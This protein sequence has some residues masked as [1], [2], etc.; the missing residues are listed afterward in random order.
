LFTE[1]HDCPPKEQLK[2]LENML[3]GDVGAV[4]TLF[5]IAPLGY[6]TG[7]STRGYL[8][9]TG[10]EHLEMN[11]SNHLV[12]KFTTSGDPAVDTQQESWDPATPWYEAKE[13]ADLLL[14][15]EA[16]MFPFEVRRAISIFKDFH[17]SKNPAGESMYPAP[18]Y[19]RRSFAAMLQFLKTRVRVN[20]ADVISF[21]MTPE[22]MNG[23]PNQLFTGSSEGFKTINSNGNFSLL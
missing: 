19:T 13:F 3:L 5:G 22:K 18:M 11:L 2:M 4:C 10:M 17:E 12:W 20:W 9:D 7:F 8:Q 16:K 1:A 21:V 23:L 6:L 15:I 14:K